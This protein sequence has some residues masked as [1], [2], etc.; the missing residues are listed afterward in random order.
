[1]FQEKKKSLCVLQNSLAYWTD[2]VY[3]LC[4]KVPNWKIQEG[5]EVYTCGQEAAIGHLSSD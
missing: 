5:P 3:I 4:S 2:G 1:V